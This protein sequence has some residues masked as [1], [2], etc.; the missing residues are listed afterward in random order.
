M[1]LTYQNRATRDSK[2]RELKAAGYKVRRSSVRNQ[3]LHPQYVDDYKGPEKNDTGLGNTVYKTHFSVL[4]I[5][6][7]CLS[8][9]FRQNQLHF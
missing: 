4:Y 6:N 1:K 7:Y 5:V 2:A 9:P 3:L 8:D